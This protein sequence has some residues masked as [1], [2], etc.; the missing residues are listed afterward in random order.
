M[1]KFTIMG[2]D[3]TL[4]SEII[5]NTI[6]WQAICSQPFLKFGFE[7]DDITNVR[8]SGTVPINHYRLIFGFLLYNFFVRRNFRRFKLNQQNRKIFLISAHPTN[9]SPPKFRYH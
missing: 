1:L 3:I 8:W 4:V 6:F 5:V 9:L 2:C 7:S